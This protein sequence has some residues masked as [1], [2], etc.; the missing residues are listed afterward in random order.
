MLNDISKSRQYFTCPQCLLLNRNQQ[1]NMSLR[2]SENQQQRKYSR[3]IFSITEI[4]KAMIIFIIPRPTLHQLPLGL[5]AS[6]F[7]SG[8]VSVNQFTLLQISSF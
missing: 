4:R 6:S 5:F 3:P 7:K 1:K 8:V 2:L